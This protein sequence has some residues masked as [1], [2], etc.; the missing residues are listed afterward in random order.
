MI[1][2]EDLSGFIG[3]SFASVWAL[4]L[5][6]LL[7]RE[8]R[9]WATDELVGALRASDLVVAQALDSLVAAGL[10]SVDDNGAAYTPVSDAVAELVDRGAE[11]YAIKPD[12]VRRMIVTSSARG[13]TAFADAFKLRKD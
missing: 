13:I 11:L 3:S 4:E 10:V 2:S 7:R 12:A 6:L 5:L 8:R 9:P 1:S